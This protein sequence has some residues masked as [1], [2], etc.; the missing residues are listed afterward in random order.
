MAQQQAQVPGRAAQAGPQAANPAAAQQA[1]VPGNPSTQAAANP[2]QPG[3]VAQQA[4]IPLVAAL[5][6]NPMAEA[7]VAVQGTGQERSQVALEQLPASG[8]T[9]QRGVRRSL[10]ERVAGVRGS[11]LQM[12]GLSL[13]DRAHPQ[14][15]QGHTGRGA[16]VAVAKGMWFALPWLFWLLA[17]VA[18]GCLALA[19][20][21]MIGGDAASPRTAAANGWVGP[22]VLGC[23][24]LA[25]VGAWHLMRR[26]R[27]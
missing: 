2:A 14:R 25:A 23:G 18:Y 6:G 13:P 24:L 19:L 12:L 16:D 1:A 8:H 21:V 20:V 3:T 26:R 7:R 27:G 9:A 4:A 11:L 17:V 5:A 10:R 22:L 15:P